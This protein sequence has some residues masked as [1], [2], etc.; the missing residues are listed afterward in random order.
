MASTKIQ[1]LPGASVLCN[2]P[3]THHHVIVIENGACSYRLTVCVPRRV[4][5][6]E[7]RPLRS[8]A[9]HSSTRIVF[10][11]VSECVLEWLQ[12]WARN[13]VAPF[14]LTC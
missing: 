12:C 2:Y 13:T 8:V 9:C 7:P 10:L 5:D 4:E 14:L 3:G 6:L 11:C 1:R